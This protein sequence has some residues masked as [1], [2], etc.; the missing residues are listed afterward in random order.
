[1]PIAFLVAGLPLN[2][3]IKAHFVTR[4]AYYHAGAADVDILP[5]AERS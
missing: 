5:D 3:S 4:S 2:I 1:M